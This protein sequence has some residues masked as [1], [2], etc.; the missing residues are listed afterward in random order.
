MKKLRIGVR[1]HDILQSDAANLSEQLRECGAEVVQL[2][3]PKFVRWSESTQS[4]S[5]QK[6]LELKNAF[7]E[8]NVEI[9]VLSSYINPLASD[10]KKEQDSFRRFSEYCNVLGVKIIGTETGSVVS[11]LKDYK[12]NLK[13]EHYVRCKEVLAPVI[14]YANERGVCV[15]IETV[16]YFPVCS[17]ERFQRLTGDLKECEICS[18]FDATNLLNIDNYER[19]REIIEEFIRVNAKKIKVIHLKDFV[20]ENGMLAERALF[21]GGLDVEFVLKKVNEYG[22][23]ADIIVENS[24]STEQFKEIAERLRNIM[25][26]I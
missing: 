10:A 1:I 9:K 14:K 3:L 25:K 2:T 7:D 24:R 13:E 21:T 16:S 15:G 4:Y 11:D 12:I 18:I 19:Q 23:D 5:T 8:A 6:L 17:T 26:E 20:V 22:V